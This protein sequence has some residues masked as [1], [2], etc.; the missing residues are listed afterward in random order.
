MKP[1]N[2]S[3][4]RERAKDRLRSA[5]VVAA[6]EM[7]AS[8][9]KEALSARKLSAAVGASTK[10]IYSHFGGMPGVI[11]EVYA[12]A[13]NHLA[14]VLKAAD[15]SGELV[16]S[17][18][19]ATARAYRHFAL[20]NPTLFEL[21]YGS[22]SRELVPERADREVATASLLVFQEILSADTGNDRTQ[23]LTKSYELWTAIHGPVS[24]EVSAW[25]MDDRV[26]DT[27]LKRA[28]AAI[29]E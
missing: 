10:I 6:A 29:T 2:F 8:G 9:G 5:V 7:L 26:F 19:D 20:D 24:L 3:K 21:M 14:T 23:I 18:L 27:A 1:Y 25:L 17:R 28:I 16:A 11:A 13:F 4:D 12:S 15:K 22:R